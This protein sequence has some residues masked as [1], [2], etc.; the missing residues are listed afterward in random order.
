MSGCLRFFT[1]VASGEKSGALTRIAC[2]DAVCGTLG[3]HRRRR[4]TMGFARKFIHFSP[5][6]LTLSRSRP[7]VTVRNHH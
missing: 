7:T 1:G 5:F 2:T 4:V 6:G 3:D